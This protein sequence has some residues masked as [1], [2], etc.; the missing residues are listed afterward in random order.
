M[1]EGA[2]GMFQNGPCSD[3]PPRL[4]PDTKNK[5]PGAHLSKLK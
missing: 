3:W 2:E 5:I 4:A 1:K